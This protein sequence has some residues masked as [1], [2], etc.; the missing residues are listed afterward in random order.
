[1]KNSCA[2]I[3]FHHNKNI[4]LYKKVFEWLNLL[5]YE[6]VQ[7]QKISPAHASRYEKYQFLSHDIRKG[8]KNNLKSV[9]FYI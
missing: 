1:M 2:H 9:S 8:K 3:R 5:D 6:F 7:Q 4:I